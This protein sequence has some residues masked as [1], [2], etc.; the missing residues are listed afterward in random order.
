MRFAIFKTM[1]MYLARDRG[2]AIMAFALPPIVFIIFAAIF[3]GS[4]GGKLDLKVAV[5]DGR[6]SSESKRLL[7]SLGNNGKVTL[8]KIYLDSADDVGSWVRNGDADVGLVIM[9]NGTPFGTLMGNAPAPLQIVA[10]PSREI[11]VAGFNGALQ[12]SFVEALPDAVLRGVVEMVDARFFKLSP[13]QHTSMERSLKAIAK[14]SEQGRELPPITQFVDRRDVVSPKKAPPDVIYYA[15]AVAILFLLFS[16]MN[17]AQTLL[18]ERETGLLQRLVSGSAS[19]GVVVDGKFAFITLQ[20]VAQVTVVYLVGWGM[21][22]VPILDHALPWLLTTVFAAASAAGLALAFVSAC[23]TRQQAASLGNFLILVM[24]AIGG[25]MVP[26]FLMPEFFQQLGWLTPN[27]WVLEAY[28]VTF[29]RED[30]TSLVIPIGALA[31]TAVG[32]LWIAKTLTR[33]AMSH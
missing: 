1:W 19:V 13:K 10:E 3:S 33:R 21:F 25:S 27:T 15:G 17:A 5:Y 30:L 31:L 9:A 2:A 6:E 8:R 18:E 26:R 12:K 14:L 11:A 28:S 22:G 24:S 29:W 16:A 20:G 4:T 32:G 23:S 7:K